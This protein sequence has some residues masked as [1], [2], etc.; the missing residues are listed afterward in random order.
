MIKPFNY[1]Y[2][3]FPEDIES[4]VGMKTLC[5]DRD[6]WAPLYEHDVEYIERD[7]TKLHL[8]VLKPSCWDKKLKCPC[9]VYIQGSAFMKQNTYFSLPY[10]VILAKK[11]YADIRVE[12]RPSDV[13]AF[14]AQVIDTKT[15]IRYIRKNAEFYNVDPD[16]IFVFGDSSGGHTALMVGLTSGISWLDSDDYGEYSDDVNA[17]IDFYGPTDITKMND[18]PSIQDHT[19]PDSPEGKLIGGKNV[20]EN[21]EEARKTNP[22]T[23]ISEQKDI[24]PI[25][26][27]HGSKDRLVPFNQSVLLY[28]ALLDAGKQVEFYKLKGAD[29][30]GPQFWTDEI[31]DILDDFIKK[32]IK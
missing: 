13:A 12:Y 9:V 21:L 31:I 1:T 18:C 30:G 2:E 32:N 23:Y 27:M 5:T 7:G 14:P 28:Q 10:L 29:H 15:A 8:Q 3:S 4:P 16:N 24:P 22:I 11:G 6:E 25:L 26:I 19:G 17:V 20:L